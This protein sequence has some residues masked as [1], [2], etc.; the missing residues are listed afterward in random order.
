MDRETLTDG[1]LSITAVVMIVS[2][3]WWANHVYD[4]VQACLKVT[5][6]PNIGHCWGVNRMFIIGGVVFGLS[7]ICLLTVIVLQYRK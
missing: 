5:A 3:F 1:G 4:Q 7:G 2:G 6:Q